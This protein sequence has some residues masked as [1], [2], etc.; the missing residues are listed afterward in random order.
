[1]F[2]KRK[3][4]TSQQE[5]APP[6]APPP[7]DAEKKASVSGRVLQEV[8]TSRPLGPPLGPPPGLPPYPPPRSNRTAAQFSNPDIQRVTQSLIEEI[9]SLKE[10]VDKNNTDAATLFGLIDNLI[11][12]YNKKATSEAEANKKKEEL[13]TLQN[14]LETALTGIGV[15]SDAS[16][17]VKSAVGVV[18]DG[19]IIEKV[20]KLKGDLSAQKTLNADTQANLEEI[21]AKLAAVNADLKDKE[22][23]ISGLQIAA[24][25]KQA[26]IKRLETEIQNLTEA[27]TAE[28]ARLEQEQKDA[29]A[30]NDADRERA[31][32]QEKQEKTQLQEKF[33]ALQSEFQT[34]STNLVQL[35]NQ[36]DKEKEELEARIQAVQTQ[37]DKDLENAQ[38]DSE[39]QKAEAAAEA[40]Q[41]ASELRQQIDAKTTELESLQSK[42]G[43]C[44]TQI[45]NLTKQLDIAR[46]TVTAQVKE[47]NTMKLG[48]DKTNT[49]RQEVVG[50]IPPPINT[51]TRL[52][53]GK[54]KYT[55]KGKK[56]SI[57]KRTRKHVKKM[58]KRAS[59]AKN[60][61]KKRTKRKQLV[62]KRKLTKRYKQVG[63]KLN[64]LS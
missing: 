47:L 51:M 16:S 35:Q 23:S 21:T 58:K 57:K 19:I 49:A 55:R 33:D 17:D 48:V 34:K 14:Q 30:T 44:D 52:S 11:D 31:I 53:G 60:K 10:V 25:D 29:I 41:E 46:Q 26:A 54:K 5:A 3:T 38:T 1:M 50:R 40:A 62:K 39:R 7:A 18:A 45:A 20:N 56:K 37:A 42:K 61:A 59:H 8:M 6:A 43:I 2:S 28:I 4:K 9:E 15:N 13:E 22:A 12:A 63:G 24:A 27:N 36:L 32:Q 64:S